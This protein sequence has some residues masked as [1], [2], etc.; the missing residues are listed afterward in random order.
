MY[1]KIFMETFVFNDIAGNLKDKPT[2]QQL[3]NQ[4]ALIKEE[5]EETIE[6]VE[7]GDTV[8]TIDGAADILYTLNGFNQM[9]NKAG[10]NVVGANL[11]VC[12]NNLSK[13]IP[14]SQEDCMKLID[15]TINYYKATFDIDVGE[16]YNS[17]YDVFVL[18]NLATSKIVKPLNY[19][20]VSLK[21]YIPKET[22]NV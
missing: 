13:F 12:E 19:K 10:Y 4:L 5:L 14:A 22:I 7:M 15:D 20:S 16:F 1:N 3:L 17:E 9:L 8:E 21:N 6:A 11:E 2:K 18:K